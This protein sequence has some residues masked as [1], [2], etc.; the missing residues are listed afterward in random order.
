M[1]AT[2]PRMARFAVS[3]ETAIVAWNTLFK[4]E[5]VES[6]KSRLHRQIHTHQPK[7]GIRRGAGSLFEP[8]VLETKMRQMKATSELGIDPQREKSTSRKRG[9]KDV[10]S[11]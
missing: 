5:S 3:F 4:K 2:V 9:S 6:K 10:E 11:I 7:Y 8:P 1:E